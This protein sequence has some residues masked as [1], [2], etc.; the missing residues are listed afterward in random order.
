MTPEEMNA[1]EARLLKFGASE[2]EAMA[3]ARIEGFTLTAD[4]TDEDVKATIVAVSMG[5]ERLVR[6][7]AL[8]DTMAKMKGE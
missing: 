8:W 1:T 6:A 5:P 3:L 4:S 7:M 2:A